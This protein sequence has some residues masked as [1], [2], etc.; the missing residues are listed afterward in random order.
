MERNKIRIKVKAKKASKTDRYLSKVLKIVGF[1]FI[2]IAG[3]YLI[4]SQDAGL[5]SKIISLFSAPE[6]IAPIGE[7]VFPWKPFSYILAGHIPGIL[8]LIWAINY[9]KKNTDRAYRFIMG[10]IVSMTL[11]NTIIYFYW[12]IYFGIF[13]YYNYFIASIFLSITLV[14]FFISYLIYKRQSLLFAILIY[15]HIFMLEMLA[16]WVDDRYLYIFSAISIFSG[17]LFYISR[18]DKPYLTVFSNALFAH[19]FLMILVLKKFVFNTSP[20]YLSLFFI[21]SFLYF[22]IYYIITLYY[23]VIENK[24][25][26]Q[27]INL[28]N[29]FVYI[30]LN[31]Y[32]LSRFGYSNYYGIILFIAFAVHLSSL[33]VHKKYYQQKGKLSAIEIACLVLISA[34]V[35]Q[36]WSEYFYSLFMGIVSILFFLYA[37]QNKNKLYVT[38]VIISLI[39]LVAN[40]I[41]LASTGYFKI[42][43]S[44]AL[45]TNAVLKNVFINSILV[46]FFVTVMRIIVFNEKKEGDQNWFNRSRY[47]RYLNILLAISSFV[48][49]EWISF[50]FVKSTVYELPFLNK[51]IL[52]IAGLFAL[53][54]LIKGDYFS[55][56]NKNW[57]YTSIYLFAI[58]LIAK[59]H[60]D[61][62]FTSIKYIFTNNFTMAEVLI[63]YIELLLALTVFAISF[64]RLYSLNASKKKDLM[65]FVV[66]TLYFVCTFLVCKEY[67]YISI[68]TSNL[69]SGISEVEFDM[70]VKSNQYLPYSMIILTCSSIL[71]IIGIKLKSLFLRSIAILIIGADL[72]KI[73]LIEFKEIS[74][75]YKAFV[76]IVIGGLLLLLSWYYNKSKQH[77]SRRTSRKS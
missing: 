27:V 19:G 32:V 49:I 39:S 30:V 65:Q 5:V 36:I 35:S 44:S 76:F 75:S 23:S 41:Y 47:V 53:F 34:S 33:I 17:V 50:F 29:T 9:S 56:K 10:I 6:V 12:S 4:D 64:I 40:L 69:S 26:F 63:H 77:K 31:G 55:K 2:A 74:E 37:K 66:F 68:L 62:S 1:L 52:F 24:K 58:F 38:A 57:V 45:E 15:F 54:I 14:L 11:F 8:G 3:Y 70:I 42:L 67:D 28:L 72:I 7:A 21:I 22:L 61:F 13:C 25:I 51:T 16:Q 18:Q 59:I 60:I 43:N 73:F 46:C 20:S 71:L 48:V